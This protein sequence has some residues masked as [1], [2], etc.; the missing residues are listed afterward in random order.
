MLFCA[1]VANK[2]TDIV[3]KAVK[4]KYFGTFVYYLGK[5]SL[6]IGYRS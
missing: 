3:F 4:V 2:A 1:Y 6:A 5:A